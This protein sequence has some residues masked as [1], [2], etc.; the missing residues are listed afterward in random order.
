MGAW[1]HSNMSGAIGVRRERPTRFL[2]HAGSGIK[3]YFT[4]AD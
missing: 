2:I 1:H 4:E 3:L